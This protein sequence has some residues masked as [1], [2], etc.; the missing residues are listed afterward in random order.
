MSLRVTHLIVRERL[1]AVLGVRICDALFLFGGGFMDISC[2]DL[3][4]FRCC[5]V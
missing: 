4:V 5:E 1:I 3:F 2:M